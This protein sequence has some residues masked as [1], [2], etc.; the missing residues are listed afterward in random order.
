VLYVD[1]DRFIQVVTNLVSN[2]LKFSPAGQ[3]VALTL[4]KRGHNVRIGVRDHGPGIPTEFRPRVFDNFAQADGGA[5]KKG[6][7]GLGLS[8]A[9]RIVTAM[10]GQI[11]F[12]DADGGGTMFFVDLPN[13]DHLGRW[14]ERQARTATPHAR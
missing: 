10:H 6:G 3:D 1:P 8:I 11:G 5:A 7:S 9:R 2:A 4:E 13:A 14:Q 12:A